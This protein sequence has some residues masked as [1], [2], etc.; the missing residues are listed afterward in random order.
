MPAEF[1]VSPGNAVV[2]TAIGRDFELVVMDGK[3][4]GQG[5]ELLTINEQGIVEETTKRNQEVVEPACP[6]RRRAM[7]LWSR[8]E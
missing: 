2:H 5:G 6:A 1:T 3:L 7:S 8:V 4:L